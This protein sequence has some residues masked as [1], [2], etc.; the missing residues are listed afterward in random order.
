MKLFHLGR[1][2]FTSMLTQF[3]EPPLPMRRHWRAASPWY[4]GV[5]GW[6]QNCSEGIAKSPLLVWTFV[7]L[8]LR[9][10][11][12]EL[13]RDAQSSRRRVVEGIQAERNWIH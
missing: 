7:S 1:N 4:D 6:I 5:Q 11:V 2:R 8:R 9:R 3:I 12:V 10:D 13:S